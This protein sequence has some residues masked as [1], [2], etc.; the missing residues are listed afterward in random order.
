MDIKLKDKHMEKG[1]EK[2]NS[3]EQKKEEKKSGK[4]E[5]KSE[6]KELKK[7]EKTEEKTKEEIEKIR[8]R[9][10]E[11]QNVKTT[12]EAEDFEEPESLK[13]VNPSLEKIVRGAPAQAPRTAARQVPDE[14]KGPA[15]SEGKKQY[16]EF[17]PGT[18]NERVY[19]PVLMTEQK[20][21]NYEAARPI[22]PSSSREKKGGLPFERKEDEKRYEV[23][24]PKSLSIVTERERE[25]K[26]KRKY[27]PA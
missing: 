3:K 25:E 14:E 21:R 8:Q 26:E 6:K 19:E 5:I 24:R 22:E 23:T 11:L 7:P 13:R 2:D 17:K 1:K 27:R 18:A 10:K 16:T 20:E 9:L 15:Y 12:E 4:L